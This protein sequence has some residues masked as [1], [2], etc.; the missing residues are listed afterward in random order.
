MSCNLAVIYAGDLGPV[1]EVLAAA[2]QRVSARV[3]VL[4]LSGKSASRALAHP[5]ADLADQARFE[6]QD[7][8]R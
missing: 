2:A 5:A 8:Q 3:R 4:A 7:G 1:A 6:R